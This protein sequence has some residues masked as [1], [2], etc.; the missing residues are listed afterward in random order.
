MGHCPFV[1]NTD[2]VCR[3]KTRKR[4]LLLCVE[5]AGAFLFAMRASWRS[6]LLY[7]LEVMHGCVSIEEDK[8]SLH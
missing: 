1:P 4:T 7:F 5:Q 8:L 2:A 6:T 3:V